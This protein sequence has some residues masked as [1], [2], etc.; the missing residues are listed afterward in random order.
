MQVDTNQIPNL[1][2]AGKYKFSKSDLDVRDLKIRKGFSKRILGPAVENATGNTKPTNPHKIIS[3]SLQPLF[4][5][6]WATIT[7]KGIPTLPVKA[8]ARFDG[9]KGFVTGLTF[10]FTSFAPN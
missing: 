10:S 4:S 5:M 9:N 8:A 1:F 3:N 7:N 2:H 6:R